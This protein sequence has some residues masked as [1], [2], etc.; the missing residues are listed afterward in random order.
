MPPVLADCL[1]WAVEYRRRCYLYPNCPE[2]WERHTADSMS[3][4]YAQEHCRSMLAGLAALGIRLQEGP[5]AC[6]LLAAEE[7][8]QREKAS[9][10]PEP[11]PLSEVEVSSFVDEF[12]TK[13]DAP[14]EEVPT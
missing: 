8:R 6:A 10:P 4:G 9:L 11:S 12:F 7:C 1:A 14:K 2:S 13:L 3:D 5:Q